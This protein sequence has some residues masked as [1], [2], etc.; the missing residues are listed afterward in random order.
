[1]HQRQVRAFNRLFYPCCDPNELIVHEKC[2]PQRGFQPTTLLFN[3]QTKVCM[4]SCLSMSVYM[5]VWVC[6]GVRMGVCVCV[7]VCLYHLIFLLL[8]KNQIKQFDNVI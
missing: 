3:H 7:R 6:V 8:S 5:G 4:C 1:M 2:S